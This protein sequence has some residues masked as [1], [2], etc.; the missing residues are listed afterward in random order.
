MINPFKEI[1]WKPGES[2]LR[3]FAISLMIGLPVISAVFIAIQWIRTGQLPEGN[4]NG[5]MMLGGFGLSVGFVCYFIHSIARPLY[6]VWYALACC[7][8]I[9][10]ANLLFALVFFGL[11]TPMGL[12]MRLIGRDALRLKFQ[13]GTPTYWQDAEAAPSPA[14]YF[15]QY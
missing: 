15:R 7:I 10:M 3:K 14:Q 12:F 6:M 13:R 8:G 9:V 11:F 4:G 5:L 2:E 1:N